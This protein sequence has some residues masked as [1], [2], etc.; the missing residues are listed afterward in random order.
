MQFV[1]NQKNP[2][3]A[4]PITIYPKLWCG[5]R[6]IPVFWYHS[7]RQVGKF[8]GYCRYIYPIEFFNVLF[9]GISLRLLG[10]KQLFPD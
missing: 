1:L 2:H 4:G 3:I 8:L 6:T 9:N 7:V 5:F 10:R